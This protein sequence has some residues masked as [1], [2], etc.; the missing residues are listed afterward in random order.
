MLPR[1]IRLNALAF[2]LVVA[3][4]AVAADASSIAMQAFLERQAKLAALGD[5]TTKSKALTDRIFAAGF[6]PGDANC[7]LDSD[8][9]TLPD[10]AETNTGVFR[11]VDDTGTDPDLAD[12]DGDGID[13]GDE[14]VGTADGL[15]LPALGVNPLRK[16][17]LVEYDWFDDAN[18]CGAHSHAPTAAVMARVAQVYADA[19]VQ[20]PDGSTGINVIQDAGQGGA[21]SGGNRVDGE[22]NL[23]GTFDATWAAIKA[24][25]FAP[26][27]AGYFRYVLLAHRYNGTSNSS[28]Y[29]EV[30]GDDALITLTCV[31]TE[32]NAARTIVHELGHNLGLHH[33][34]FEAC[35]SKPNYNS[36]MNY[37][38]QFAGLDM[39]CSAGGDG[40]TDGYSIG[41][42]VS[43]DE[44]AIDE[45][46]GVC[47]NPPID[48]NYNGSL[49]TGIALDLNPGNADTCGDALSRIH[50]FDDWSNITLLGVRDA[51]GKLAGIKSEVGCAGAP[52]PK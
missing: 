5:T 3:T 33:G 1:T 21:L 4:P 17:L 6:E 2:A 35:N 37:R 46:Q 24:A 30:V 20:N 15:D 7:T 26:G 9:D 42:R 23:P 29:A 34:G 16:D 36:L 31:Q 45:S 18:D 50:D 44:A 43:I 40:Q 38:Y 28:G 41:D 13:D 19:P 10:C 47:G 8:G 22:A 11:G 14:V 12:T 32:D 27:R 51:Q 49:E 48:W 25:N 52:A 39:T